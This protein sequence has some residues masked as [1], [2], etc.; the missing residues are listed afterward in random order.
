MNDKADGMSY[1]PKG[2]AAPVVQP[3]EFVFAAMHLD[4]GH[5]FGQCN[6]L[7]EAGATLKWVYDPDAEKVERFVKTYPGVKVA[8]SRAEVLEDPEVKLVAAAA[9]PNERG[10]LGCDVMR[11]GKDYFTDKTPFTELAQL[12]EARQV[13]AET[14]RKYM[15]YYSERLHVECAIAAGDL[16]KEGRIGRVVQVLGLG[17]HRLGKGRPGWFF[18]KK[19]YGGILC[20]IGSHQLEQFLYYTGNTDATIVNSKV[21]NYRNP[22]LPEFEDFGDIN[23]VGGNGATGYHRV[24]W[25]NPDGLGTW[26]DGRTI[27]LGTEGYIEL[28]KYINVGADRSGDHLFLV[29]HQGEHHLELAGKVG[30]P[31]FGQLILD[32]INRTENAM[33]QAHAFKAAELCLIAQEQA[34]RVSG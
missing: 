24:D 3:G 26:G 19:Q 22:T 13:V 18:A 15:V 10:P 8:R 30:F 32:C 5:I 20:D 31:Y 21:A 17:P 27:I 25:L 28:R 1:A 7:I 2:K 23:V 14:G 29:D 11:A 9:I 6:G 33:T 16:I 34:V 12:A 4:H